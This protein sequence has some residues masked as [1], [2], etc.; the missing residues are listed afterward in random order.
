MIALYELIDMLPDDLNPSFSER[1]NELF[2]FLRDED[3]KL[4]ESEAAEAFLYSNEKGKY[5]NKLKNELKREIVQYVIHNPLVWVNK[6]YKAKNEACYKNFTAYK[7][8]L[9]SGRR[10]AAIEMAKSLL[11]KLIDFELHGLINIVATDLRFHYSS[12]HISKS[13]AIKYD[14]LCNQQIEII[15]AESIVRK[16]HSKIAILCNSRASYSES[17]LETFK[18]ASAAVLP[19]LKLKSSY[20]QRYIYTI[21]QVKYSAEYDYHNLIKICND[22]IAS[23]PKEYPNIIALKFGYNQN[24]IPALISTGQLEEA[25]EVSK[26]LCKLMPEG[27]FNWHLALIRRVTVCLHIGDYQE[28]YDLYKTQLKHKC[29]FKTIVEYWNIIWGYLYFLIKADKIKAYTEERFHLGKFV[30]DMPIYS[31]DKSGH[32]IN[33]FIIQIII[34]LQ[35]EQYGQIIDRIDALRTYVKTYTKNPETTRANIFLQMIIRMEHASFHRAATER[36]TKKL[37][38]RLRS[39]NLKLGQNLA[40]EVIPYEKLWEYTLEMLENKF[41]GLTTKSSVRKP[42]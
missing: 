37:L 21:I 38:E 6:E 9:L 19:F 7:I 20:L 28:A 32:N 2:C 1:L 35:R 22:A 17:N 27:H 4:S 29:Q 12:S 13:L 39:T 11:P 26:Q 15:K 18:K 10:K 42:S 8:L 3:K 5:F 31:K 16:H 14:E 30:N 33:I 34:R 24:K 25:K 40:L 36:K 41:R 23:I